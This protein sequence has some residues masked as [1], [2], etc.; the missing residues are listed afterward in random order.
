MDSAKEIAKDMLEAIHIY[1]SGFIGAV[2]KGVIS[3]PISLAYLGYDFIDMEHR[4]ENQDDK[5]RLAALVKKVTFN[6][7][8]IYKV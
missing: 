5:F 2:A 6:D 7:E 3:L 1:G 4:R 8:V